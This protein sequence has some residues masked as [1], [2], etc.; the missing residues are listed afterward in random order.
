ML[1]FIS[2][3]INEEKRGINALNMLLLGI[4]IG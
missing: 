1:F 3:I 4:G 2:K